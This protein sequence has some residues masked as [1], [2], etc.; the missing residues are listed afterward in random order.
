MFVLVYG[1]ESNPDCVAACATS[2]DP[3]FSRCRGLRKLHSDARVIK[4]W[5]EHRAYV[6]GLIADGEIDEVEEEEVVEEEDEEDEEPGP[7]QDCAPIGTVLALCCVVVSI[8]AWL[9]PTL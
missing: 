7:N 3:L 1:S 5:D 2:P 8:M 6:E 4:L 9:H